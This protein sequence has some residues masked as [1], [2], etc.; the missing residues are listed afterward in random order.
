MGRSLEGKNLGIGIRQ[1]RDKLYQ[2]NFVDLFGKRHYLYNRNLNELKREL[3]KIKYEM[4]QG[5]NPSNKSITVE[6]WSDIWEANYKAHIREVT[7]KTYK[8]YIRHVNEAIG[9]MKI[10]NVKPMHIMMMVSKMQEK[11]Y[12]ASTIRSFKTVVHDLFQKAVENELVQR[13]PVIGIT[14]RDDDHNLK[15]KALSIHEQKIFMQSVESSHYRE[16]FGFML[17]TGLRISETLGLRWSDID[18]DEKQM[19]IQRNLVSVKRDG[20]YHYEVGP[21]KSKSSRRVIPLTEQAINFLHDQKS[22][23]LN[24]KG[25]GNLYEDLVFLT[26]SGK[27]PSFVNINKILK[28]KVQSLNKQ[29]VEIQHISTHILRH[30]FATRCYESGMSLKAISKILGHSRIETTADIYTHVLPQNAIS[31]MEK[32][33]IIEMEVYDI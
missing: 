20:H 30:S 23:E 2:G 12:A 9:T 21:T 1:R 6:A 11:G 3:R 5:I 28:S 24:K 33:Q 15:N 29:G 18:F 27:T 26:R 22:K 17:S 16:L 19:K 4:D 10:N 25:M 7:R 13:N 32:L 8:N 14:V 31:E